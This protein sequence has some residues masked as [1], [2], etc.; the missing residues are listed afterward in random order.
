MKRGAVSTSAASSVVPLNSVSIPSSPLST[1][2]IFGLGA[3]ASGGGGGGGGGLGGGGGGG[4]GGFGGG[5]GGGGEHSLNS[6]GIQRINIVA[7]LSLKL[8][9]G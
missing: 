6:R 9:S 7:D 3:R 4:G 5:G 8:G 1:T 2:V